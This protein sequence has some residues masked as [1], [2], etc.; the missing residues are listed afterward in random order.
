MYLHNLENQMTG[1]D[2]K[3]L[4]HEYYAMAQK[5]REEAAVAWGDGKRW[6]ADK[7]ERKALW[8][9]RKARQAEAR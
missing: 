4:A 7:L 8:L 6:L 9:R 5:A 2:Y 3:Q 1:I